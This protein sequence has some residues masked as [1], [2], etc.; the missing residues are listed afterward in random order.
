MQ[1][2]IFYVWLLS[3]RVLVEGRLVVEVEAEAAVACE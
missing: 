2:N 1:R 3:M